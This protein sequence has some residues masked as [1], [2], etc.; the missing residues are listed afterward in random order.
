M[1]V[2][3]KVPDNSVIIVGETASWLV[4]ID[5]TGIECEKTK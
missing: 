5:E 3:N 1:S 4:S 2:K